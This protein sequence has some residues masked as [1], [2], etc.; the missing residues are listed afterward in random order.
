MHRAALLLTVLS[1]PE[2]SFD[3]AEC[4][5]AEAKMKHQWCAACKVGYVA[6]VRIESKLLHEEIDAHGHDIDPKLMKC[7]SCQ[8]ALETDGFCERCTMGFVKKQAY[9]SRLTYFIAKG[10]TKDVEKIACPQCRKNAQ[11]PGW[12]DACGLGMVGNVALQEKSDF[13]QAAKAFDV[14]QEAVRTLKR[15]E[16]CAIAMVIDGRCPTCKVT[17]RNGARL[18][19]AP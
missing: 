4:R 6:G 14:F 10:E 12:C 3:D 18:E 5:C 13:E 16:F 11:S 2:P 1:C 9:M 19:E 8:K 17:Y 15:C 7:S